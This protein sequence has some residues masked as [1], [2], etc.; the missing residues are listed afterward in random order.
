MIILVSALIHSLQQSFT[1][2]PNTRL[3]STLNGHFEF[4]R[5]NL[6]QDVE[7]I[8][9]HCK[10]KPNIPNKYLSLKAIQ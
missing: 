5:Y 9:R 1:N 7:T 6:D 10:M 8:H 3:I 2:L 4:Q